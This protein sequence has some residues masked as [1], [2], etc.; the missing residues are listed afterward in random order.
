[1]PSFYK[2]LGRYCSEMYYMPI[3][4][5]EIH[6]IFPIV[7]EFNRNIRAR[8]TLAEYLKALISNIDENGKNW[9]HKNRL[10]QPFAYTESLL[11]FH[12]RNDASEA[13]E[14]IRLQRNDHNRMPSKS[15]RKTVE[16]YLDAIRYPTI[17]DRLSR[18]D[19]DYLS[20][21]W[22]EEY[23]YS[24]V[25]S[26]FN[27]N[28]DAI[29]LNLNLQPGNADNE[30]DIMFVHHNN[31]IIIECKTGLNDGEYDLFNDAAYKLAAVRN[32]FGISA[33]SCLASMEDLRDD[34]GKLKEKYRR[35]SV[36]LNISIADK[37]DVL[38]KD[39]MKE[40]LQNL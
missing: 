32:E 19:I 14:I 26:Q 2:R 31:L 9:K 3:N 4:S 27:L 30:F 24:L 29:A 16:K 8:L 22:L 21:G 28:D 20:G 6:K 11:E 5:N 34:D 25:K 23:I 17:F 13:A 38:S 35:R 40:I 36:A 15:E 39:R 12:G 10:Q 1:M 33:K 37:Q 18:Y 7:R